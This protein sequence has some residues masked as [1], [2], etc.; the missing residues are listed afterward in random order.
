MEKKTFVITKSGDRFEEQELTPIAAAHLLLD[1]EVISVVA[2]GGDTY[3]AYSTFHIKGV[4]GEDYSINFARKTGNGT[5]EEFEE[6][7][8]LFLIK[9]A[10]EPNSIYYGL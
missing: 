1:D 4:Y 8:E 2:R 5:E 10:S 3:C 7:L 6:T 9:M